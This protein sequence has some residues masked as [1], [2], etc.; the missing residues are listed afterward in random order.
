MSNSTVSRLGQ[1]NQAGL[2]DALFL[3]QFGGEIL[4]E[5]EIATVF[6][7][8]H[9]V[10]QIRN[11]KTAQ[12]PNIGMVDSAYHVPGQFIDGQRVNHAETVI[13]V[14]GLLVAPVFVQQI[15]ELMN[16]YDVRG[17]YATEMGRE[18]AYEFD[19]NVA[20]TGV[21]AARASNVLTG[22]SGGSA[23][24]GTNM[25][26]TV[27]TYRAAIFTAAQTLDEKR[28][29]SSDRALFVRPAQYYMLAQDTILINKDYSGAGSIATG[30]IE[31]VAGIDLVKTL[32]LPQTNLTAD[33]TVFSK[34]R[35]DYSK[36]VG[37]VMNK[38]A[39]GTVQLMDVSLES[40]WEMRRQGTFMIAKLAVG[41][42][43]L[44]PDCAV[45]LA[46]T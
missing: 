33:G 45:E 44:R 7:P 21:L 11:G 32:H 24:T 34:Y 26:T 25:G 10:R 18:L 46:N 16:H 38:M 13:S 9:F 3:K 37:L 20:R 14:D 15:D 2:D 36:T 1:V 8:R 22:R 35:A 4:T 28:I 42:G 30:R 27:A 23:I 39:V 40:E 19:K 29:S 41:H 12:F 43:V 5:F 6:K 17:P 31:T